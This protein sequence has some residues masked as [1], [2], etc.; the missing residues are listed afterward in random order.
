MHLNTGTLVWQ[1]FG[2]WGIALLCAIALYGLVSP[3]SALA[4]GGKHQDG[5]FT[6]FQAVQKAITLYDQLI[7]QGKLEPGWETELEEIEV[8]T[9]TTG[10]R[11]DT[12][13]SFHRDHGKPDTVY[14][15]FDADG[16]YAGSNFSGE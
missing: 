16:E 10:E 1:S 3:G 2:K 13:V 7:T 11:N 14:I 6:R 15:F 9:R 5:K 12:V 4:H 8:N